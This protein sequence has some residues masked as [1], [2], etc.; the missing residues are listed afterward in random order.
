[1]AVQNL[2]EVYFSEDKKDEPLIWT[3]IETKNPDTTPPNLDIN[4]INVVA[5][6]TNPDN[7]NGETVVDIH[8]YVRDDISGYGIG[9]V[10]IRDPLGNIH[11]RWHYPHDNRGM[12]VNYVTGKYRKYT[13][14]ILLP[15]GSH[16]GIWG[17]TNIHV[18]DKAGNKKDYDFTEIVR[19]EVD[20]D[21]PAA[22][23]RVQN[24]LLPN[25]PNPFNPETWI[26]YQLS[27]LADVTVTISAVDGTFVRK[28]TLGHK[29]M[30]ISVE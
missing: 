25:Y 24:A 12:Y 28:L 1:M 19:F 26:P 7:P 2:H 3:D 29:P 27:A 20:E 6:P 23:T 21:V 14:Q 5:T 11:H 9:G 13:K 30:G 8:F 10:N 22:P 4:R 15:V 17:I 18:S 16:P